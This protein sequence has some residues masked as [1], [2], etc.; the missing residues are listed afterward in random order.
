MTFNIWTFVFEVLNFLVLAFVLHR[1]LYRPLREAI[2]RRRAALAQAQ[3]QADKARL[4]AVA[5]QQQLEQRLADIDRERQELLRKSHEQAETDRR[6]I[7]AEAEQA[8]ERRQEEV[9]QA[10]QRERDEALHALEAEGVSLAVDLAGRLLAEAADTTLNRQLALHLLE[11]LAHLSEPEREQ[12]R[13]H[14]QPADG[15]V[16]EAAAEMDAETVEQFT[17]AVA[18]IL[19][20]PV[21]LAIHA[22]LALLAGVRLRLGGHVWDASLAGQM[23]TAKRTNHRVTESS[24]RRNA[25]KKGQD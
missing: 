9:R 8:V 12:L 20:Q 24:E 10:L 23:Q 1:L 14:W 13:R 5:L 19:G 11:A 22:D 25:E 18:T 16:L 17:R 3:T 7:M 15:A 2:D 6:A 21:S 4:D